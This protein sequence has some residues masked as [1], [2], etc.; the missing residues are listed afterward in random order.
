MPLEAPARRGAEAIAGVAGNAQRA[1]RHRQ[2][3]VVAG[4]AAHVHPA[5]SHA[6]RDAVTGVALDQQLTA[7]HPGPQAGDA[8][9]RP[10]DAHAVGSLAAN[11]EEIAEPA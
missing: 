7:G 9:H 10:F 3:G 4:I 11:V 1:A 5:A 8:P 2:A 6:G